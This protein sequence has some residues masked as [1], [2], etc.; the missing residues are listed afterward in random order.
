MGKL[1]SRILC[2]IGA[3][4]PFRD[5]TQREDDQLIGHA[6]HPTYTPSEPTTPVTPGEEELQKETRSNARGRK[7]KIASALHIDDLEL[8]DIQILAIDKVFL[9]SIQP[10]NSLLES[11][12]IMKEAEK[13]FK[14]LVGYTIDDAF[15][16]CFEHCKTRYKDI[17]LCVVFKEEGGFKLCVFGDVS[18]IPQL[19]DHLIRTVSSLSQAV[20]L[21][22][23]TAPRAAASLQELIDDQHQFFIMIDRL[24][25]RWWEKL[26]AKQFLKMNLRK[27]EIARRLVN[28]IK[29]QT[30]DIVEGITNSGEIL[31]RDLS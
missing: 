6:R 28:N 26:R 21:V 8:R 30:E 31:A 25:L 23:D 2:C 5:S 3:P 29:A 18:M 12:R 1:L 16:T 13:T 20:Q 7:F 19:L 27:C 17:K 15:E 4:H 22:L 24:N 9:E 10:Y 11:Y 14:H